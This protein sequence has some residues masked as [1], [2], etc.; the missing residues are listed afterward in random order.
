MYNHAPENYNCPICLGVEGIE[1]DATML[2]APDLVYRDSM[3]SVFVNSK[4]VKNNPGHVIVVPNE[5][6]ENIY[7]MPDD[8]TNRVMAVARQLAVALK[9]VRKCDG[10]TLLQNNEPASNQH[11]F[12]YHLHIYPRFTKDDW[13]S[14]VYNTE[15]STPEQRRPYV[16]A[17]Q[18]YLVTNPIK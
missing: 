16:E 17:L 13:T 7:A 6:Y 2:K 9:E 12:H 3:V 11:A 14:F 18:Q 15:I 4:F 5:H 10:V 1:S 8:L